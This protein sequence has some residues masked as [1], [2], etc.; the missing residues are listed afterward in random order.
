[1]KNLAIVSKLGRSLSMLKFKAKV[2]TPEILVIAGIGG[3]VASGVLACVATKKLEDILE[4]GKEDLE[5]VH[6]YHD[7][8][9]DDPEY[10]D[11]DLSQSI[12][13]IYART[14]L[15]VVKLYAPAVGLGVVSIA[16]II[17]SNNIL[18]KR[19]MA[20]VAAYTALDKGFKE[21]RARVTERFGSE[22]ENE[23]RYNLKKEVVQETVIDDA[24]NE[25]IVNKEVYTTD[26][27]AGYS[28]YAK[29][30]CESSKIWSK[31]PGRNLMTVRAQQTYAND[32]L[33]TRG[34]VFL[35]EVYDSLGIELTEAGQL[36]GWI[37]DPSRKDIA[38]NI[39]FGLTETFRP[40][41]KDFI[42][43]RERTVLLDFN[44]DGPIL[45]DFW[46]VAR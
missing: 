17:A 46:K 36:V 6:E 26:E 1:M 18:R 35:N 28:P 22:V 40:A 5:K 11:K 30:F 3:V 43:G 37:F 39:D 13:I 31:E 12:S 42:E 33:R 38:N 15:E 9:P 14:G 23:I 19:N 21:Y 16:A 4:K 24:G 34:Y 2:K 44:V 32:L 29:F 41:M 8:H 20:L 27:N 10:T 45:H 25:T 7:K